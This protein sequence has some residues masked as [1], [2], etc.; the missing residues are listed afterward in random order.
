MTINVDGII[1]KTKKKNFFLSGIIVLFQIVLS[2]FLYISLAAHIIWPEKTQGAPGVSQMISYEGYLTDSSDNPLGGTGT[3]YCFRFSI[4]DNETVG[5]GT[6]LWPS[7][8]PS[9][10][11]ATTTD[12][13]FSALIGQADALT[14]NFYDSDTVYLNIEVNTTP[15]TCAGSWETLSPRQT[16]AASGYAIASESVYGDILRTDI[17]NNRAQIGTGAGGASP[18]MLGLDVKNTTD[19]IGTSCTTNGTIWYNSAISKALVCENSL[20]QALSNAGTTTI[21]ALTTN[22]GSGGYATTGTVVFSNSNGVTFGINGNT[23]TAS[24]AAAGGGNTLSSTI[25]GQDAGHGTGLGSLGQNTVYL[26]PQRLDAAV[27]GSIIKMPVSLSITS[28]AFAA[29]TRGYTANFGIYTRNATNSTVLSLHYSTSYTASVS[30]NSNGTLNLGIITAIGNSTSYNTLSAS[31]AGFNLTASIN[32]QRE[33]IMPLNTT[34]SAGEYWLAFRQ[35]SSS[36]GA[37]GALWNIS[38]YMATTVTGN[39]IGLSTNSTNQGILRN[40]G[41]GIYSATSAALPGGISM[42]QINQLG[43]APFAYFMSSTE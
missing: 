31:S 3:P 19:Y 8:T 29:H 18:K 20:I 38:H 21:A 25:F 34:L 35:S 26:Y 12:G 7:G 6:K 27:A 39:R 24:V 42:T 33:L 9:T 16:I 36:A 1:I 40:I 37:A 23:I 28:S 17:S 41:M 4:Y 32:G 13:V 11:K 2:V 10:T 30:A 14:Y 15:S 5:Q 43:T 22:S